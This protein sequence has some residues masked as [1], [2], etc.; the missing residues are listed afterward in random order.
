VVG[1]P[2]IRLPTFKS[3]HRFFFWMVWR[4]WSSPLEISPPSPIPAF[5]YLLALDDAFY[6]FP[7][8]TITP[9]L[10]SLFLNH[11]WSTFPADPVSLLLSKGSSFAS[12][13]GERLPRLQIRLHWRDPLRAEALF[14]FPWLHSF[15]RLGCGC[16]AEG[17]FLLPPS[18]QKIS[19][20]PPKLCDPR[21]LS[22]G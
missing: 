12:R 3:P 22:L 13:Y 18:E 5:S 10:A 6:V 1:S 2:S 8:P 19:P 9:P 11:G 16:L 14:S 17:F 15:L 21:G 7:P 20:S 4:T